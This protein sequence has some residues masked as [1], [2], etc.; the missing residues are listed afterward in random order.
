MS[1]G[2]EAGREYGAA[3]REGS[4]GAAQPA[5]QLLSL[6]EERIASSVERHRD[7]RKRIEDLEAALA[8]H[9][10]HIAELTGR[11]TEQQRVRAEARERVTRLIERVAELERQPQGVGRAE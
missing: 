5:V 4:V 11:A 6:L 10:A 9:E 3:L 7:S 8:E 1:D 2:G